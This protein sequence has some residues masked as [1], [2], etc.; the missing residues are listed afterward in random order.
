MRL[1]LD[2]HVLIWAATDTA[3]LAAS[4]R[5][6]L[7]DGENEVL[8]SAVVGWE[9]AIKQS[10]GKLTLAAPAELWV[11][12]VVRRSGFELADVTMAAALGAR[13]LPW[14]HKD[15]FDRLLIAHAQALAA[16]IVTHDDAFGAYGVPLLQ[17]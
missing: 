12:E 3:R 10:I 9:I 13:A 2:T 14:H 4:A 17:A 8:V 6:A 15:P 7:E 16:T 11:P 1:L 5:A